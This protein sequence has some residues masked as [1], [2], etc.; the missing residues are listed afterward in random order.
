MTN[1]NTFENVRSWH[2]ELTENADENII[3]YL[4]ANFADL[5]EEREVT[6][7]QAIALMKELGM[8]HYIET[9]AQTGQN[10]VNL[11]ETAT[12]HI[13]L[14]NEDSLDDYVSKICC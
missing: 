1:M 7:E 2:S 11:F 10:I 13:F 8:H 4:V 3:I 5:E 6:T 14:V 9:S 12:K